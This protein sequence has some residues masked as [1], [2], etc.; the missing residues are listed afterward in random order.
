MRPLAARCRIDLALL[1]RTAGDAGAARRE[2]AAALDT[3][4]DLG[5]DV[6]PR[7]AAELAAAGTLRRDPR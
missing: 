5:L 4:R 7:V 2:L 6:S 1:H 3:L